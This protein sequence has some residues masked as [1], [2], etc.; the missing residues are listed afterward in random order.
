MYIIIDMALV[1][2]I[3]KDLL[4]YPVTAAL[5]QLAAAVSQARRRRSWTQADLAAK[6]EI[7]LSTLTAIEK[8]TPSVQL[9]HWLKVLWAMD[10]TEP[11]LQALQ[12][13]LTQDLQQ[14]ANEHLPQRVRRSRA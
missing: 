5:E 14:H 4:P 10:L 2:K 11:L 12:A 9:G 8:G 7:S 3:E 6:A 13:S 1:K